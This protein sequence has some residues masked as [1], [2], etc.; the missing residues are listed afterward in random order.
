MK[1]L[2]VSG[3]MENGLHIQTIM[4]KKADFSVMSRKIVIFSAYQFLGP[5]KSRFFQKIGHRQK[6]GNIGKHRQKSANIGKNREKSGKNRERS[7]KIGKNRQIGEKIGKQILT[8]L[9]YKFCIF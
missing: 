3:L 5:K 2:S 8:L 7:G 4:E 1:W 6:S 9:K